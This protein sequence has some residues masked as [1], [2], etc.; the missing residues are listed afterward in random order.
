MFF[1]EHAPP[2]FHAEYGEFK[3]TIGIREL[4]ILTGFLPRR[5]QELVLDWAELH[6]TELLAD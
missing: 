2:L 4:N 3:A 1:D 6:Q 5:V